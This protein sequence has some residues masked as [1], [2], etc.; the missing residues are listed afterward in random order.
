MSP[1]KCARWFKAAALATSLGLAAAPAL[2][3][4]VKVAHVD[5]LSGPFALVG[6]SDGRMLQAAIDD[7]NAKG[8]VLGGTKLELL[9]FDSKSSPQEAVLILKQIIDSGVRFISLG[10]GSH[11]AHALIDSL[12][13]HNS[14]NPE[15]AVLLLNIAAQDPPLTNEKCSFW[16]FRWEAHTDMRVNALTDF[17]AKQK[18]VTPAVYLI[19]QDYAFGQAISRAA[20]E[21]LAA[22]R[23]DIKIVGDDLHPLGKVKDFAPYVSKIKASGANTVLTGNW[24]PDL[25][26]LI[27]ASK[28]AGLGVVYYT[29]NAHNAGV[30]ASIGKAGGDH[31]RQV[32][33][34]HANV[35]DNKAEKFANDYRKRFNEDLWLLLPKLQMDMLAKAINTA[36]SADP[37]KV[38]KALHGMKFQGE[39]GDAWMRP[40][41]HQLI[42]AQYIAT[43][44]KAG[45]PVKYEA[46]GT[47]LGWKTDLRIEAK[48]GAMPTTCKMDVPK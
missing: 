33:T 13:K 29:L 26:L 39:T 9:H 14:R 32:F 47:G 20:K 25:S 12:N 17:I 36:Q 31:I 43:F 45:G 10:S 18:G 11:I 24:G 35:A 30:P 41:D 16:H 6:E 19:N 3:E 1:T 2:A 27:K 34:W 21:M 15:Q 4:T 44:T 5:P 23:P 7:I 40:E 46:E 38:A 48:D 28:E 8:G 37:V 42:V 22:K